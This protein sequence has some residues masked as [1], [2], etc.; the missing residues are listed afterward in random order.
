MTRKSTLVFGS[1][2]LLFLFTSIAMADS[3]TFTFAIGSLPVAVTASSNPNGMVSMA[4]VDDVVVK[5]SMGTSFALP[6]AIVTITS[7][8]NAWYNDAAGTVA[9]LYGGSAVPEVIVTSAAVCGGTCLLGDLNQGMYFAVN[10]DGGVW[11]GVYD[12]TYVSPDILAL[13]GENG[14]YLNP[15]GS[16]GFTTNNN[17]VGLHLTTAQLGSGSITFQTYT[18]EPGTLILVGT[19]ILGLAKALR[20]S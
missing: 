9:A 4:P 15:N 8:S 3:I 12:L 18:P 6:D 13:F 1:L 5:N 19:G 11:G 14:W 20:R 16:D 2:A 17:V 7:H 10:G